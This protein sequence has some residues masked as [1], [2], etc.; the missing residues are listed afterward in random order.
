MIG[1]TKHSNILFP[2]TMKTFTQIRYWNNFIVISLLVESKCNA[3][4]ASK[5]ILQ[6]KKI[7]FMDI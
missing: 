3:F 6:Q 4:I 2:E 1:N 5:K 7:F